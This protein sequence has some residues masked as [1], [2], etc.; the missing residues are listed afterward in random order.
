MVGGDKL[1]EN[2]VLITVLAKEIQMNTYAVPTVSSVTMFLQH[3]S[4]I[5]TQS[6]SVISLGTRTYT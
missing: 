1:L 3:F 5:L 6:Y 2:F 4:T